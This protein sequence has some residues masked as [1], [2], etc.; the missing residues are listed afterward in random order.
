MLEPINNDDEIGDIMSL[1]ELYARYQEDPAFKH[2]RTQPGVKFVPGHGP[3]EPDL[4]LIGEAP[5]RIENAKGI[6]FSG[7]A[8]MILTDLLESVSID[9]SKIFMTNSIKYWPQDP[10]NPG[11]TRTPTREEL[12]A[13]REYILDEIEAVNPLIVGLCGNSALKTIFPEKTGIYKWRGKLL[14]DTYVVLYHPALIS[15]KPEKRFE[16][17][18]TYFK[19][20]EYLEKAKQND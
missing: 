9:S 19:L 15:Y 1:E 8:G 11:K 12:A 17:L 2:L 3:I 16:V 4:M 5:G 18:S 20:K 13:S 10:K 6:P 7:T 14:E